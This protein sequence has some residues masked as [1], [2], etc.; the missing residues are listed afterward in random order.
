MINDQC[1]IRIEQD[2]RMAGRVMQAIR[3]SEFGG[4]D[5]LKLVTDVAVPTPKAN[6][7]CMG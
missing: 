2:V 4:G 6:E 7:V 5:V 3:V 1:T